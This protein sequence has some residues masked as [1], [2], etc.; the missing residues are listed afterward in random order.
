MGSPLGN[1]LKMMLGF[2]MGDMMVVYDL[3]RVVVDISQ[4]FRGVDGKI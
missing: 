3:I 2:E 4:V 1:S